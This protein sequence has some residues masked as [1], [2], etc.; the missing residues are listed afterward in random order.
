M[1][2]TNFIYSN[3]SDKDLKD[4]KAWIKQRKSMCES[5]IISYSRSLAKASSR[6]PNDDE[7][8]LFDIKFYS[9]QMADYA[10]ELKSIEQI[11][12]LAN[13]SFSVEEEI[14]YTEIKNKE[15]IIKA[16]AEAISEIHKYCKDL[17]LAESQELQIEEL[18]KN[19]SETI[20][21]IRS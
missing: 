12:S 7:Q 17:Q 10:I 4:L 21:Y 8:T 15:E 19:L 6:T 3:L 20:K 14:T 9:K 2:Q 16:Q 1:K 5:Q 11:E 18:I 13:L